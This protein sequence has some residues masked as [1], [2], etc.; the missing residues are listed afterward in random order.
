MIKVKNGKAILKGK[1][2]RE[3]AEDLI[4]AICGFI[5]GEID[6]YEGSS[7]EAVKNMAWILEQI[8][9]NEDYD[10]PINTRCAM[11]RAVT[12]AAEA[13]KKGKGA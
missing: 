5:G 2:N 4:A 11:Q 3:T 10:I 9:F 1:T 8:I 6:H 12:R 7:V 13:I